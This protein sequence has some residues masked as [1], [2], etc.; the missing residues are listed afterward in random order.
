MKVVKPSVVALTPIGPEL[1]KAVELAARTCYQSF[2]YI[3]EGSA[4]RMVK[5]LLTPD[6]NGVRH[7]AMIEMADVTIKVVCDRGVSHELVRHRLAS[8]AQE[9]TR[10]CNYSKEK[11]GGEITFIKPCFWDEKS[12]EYHA[13]SGLMGVIEST[14]N[15]L[16]NSGSA[17]Q[18]AR[19][20]LPNSLKTEIVMKMNVREWRHFLEVR[21]GS[22]AHPQMREVAWMI[23]DLFK[24]N[25]PLFVEDIPDTRS[26]EA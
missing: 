3:S 12:P 15:S 6:A 8:Y 23:Y 1:Y 2:D 5:Q 19:S 14:Y 4:E 17:P 21:T 22:R 10:Y 25:V 26:V 7:E 18:E 11:F 20:V 13:W 24:E 16:I 9:S